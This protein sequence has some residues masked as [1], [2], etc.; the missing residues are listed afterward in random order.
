MD[1]AKIDKNFKFETKLNEPDL[2]WY[3]A[4]KAPFVLYGITEEYDGEN[5][6]RMPKEIGDNTSAG[7][8]VL[9][10]H[11]TGIRTR[12]RTDSPCIA[13]KVVYPQVEKM[14]H[15]PLTGN[16]G[17]DIY[18]V[19]SGKYFF[20][21][22]VRP[23]YSVTTDFEGIL[24]RG[25]GVMTDY[26][27]NYPL[28]NGVCKVYIGVKEGS[29]MEEPARYINDKPVIFYGSSITQGGCATRPGNSFQ[30]FISRELDMDYINL[31]FSGNAQ[32]EQI[33]AD[34]M[35]GLDMSIFVSDYDY[36]PVK[37]DYLEATHY[38]LYETIRK[39][40]PDIPYIMVSLPTPNCCTSATWRRKIIMQ[41][42]IR[43][44]DTGDTNVY[45]ID[46]D[47]LFAGSEYDACTVD[48][49]HPN[50]M[51]FYRMARGMMPILK[52]KLYK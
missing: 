12:F 24:C 34:F 15:M 35:A 42:Y 43:A 14:T 48:N 50:D 47:S 3:D 46:G 18:R 21:G 4:S 23:D 28:Y 29:V 2:V 7:V 10:Y 31:G 45:F 9:N 30:N 33:M 16:A 6:R 41:S 17:F 37:P 11:T 38:N 36:N 51:G 22:V 19:V 49:C 5:Y 13:I 1:I 26:V 32:G 27:V 25:D 40:R 44:L 52:L 39:S 8:K 20:S